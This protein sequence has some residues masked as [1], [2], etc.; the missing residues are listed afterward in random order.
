MIDRIEIS[1]CTSMMVGKKASLDGATYI[2]RNEDRLVA[3]YPKRFVVQP[4]VTGRKET[5]V[6]PY[7]N[8][9]VPLPNP[10]IVT[11]PRPMLTKAPDQMKK[12]VLMKRM[13]AKVLPKVFMPTNGYLLMI[14]SSKM[15][16]R[17]TP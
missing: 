7:N 3:I 14:P 13:S 17:K 16:S 5:Y 11:H 8:L 10:G 4:A 12:T 2:S 9:T 1:A 6:S 15:D